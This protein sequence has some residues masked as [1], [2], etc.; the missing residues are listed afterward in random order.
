MK[1]AEALLLRA[2]MTE[3]LLRLGKRLAKNCR[4]E[5]G[6]KTAESPHTL[7]EDA[8]RLVREREALILRINRAK[9]QAKLP[10]GMTLMEALAR[11]DRLEGERALVLE[12]ISKSE[13][14]NTARKK[15]KA[16]SWMAAILREALG[17]EPTKGC[18]IRQFCLLDIPRLQ[19][20]VDNLTRQIREVN[21]LIQ[22]ANWRITLP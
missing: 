14:V 4:T 8:L 10:N 17:G 3:Q 12:I 11:R 15:N 7:L 13:V 20:R 5:K 19:A 21:A 6:Q 22:A 2:E 9:L 18:E 16:P 1:L